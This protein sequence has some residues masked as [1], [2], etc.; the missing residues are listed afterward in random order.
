MVGKRMHLSAPVDWCAG[1][2]VEEAAHVVEVV[3]YPLCMVV[4]A[5]TC[6]LCTTCTRCCRFL[7]QSAMMAERHCDC[8]LPQHLTCGQPALQK[9]G[10]MH[11]HHY[12][13]M[14]SAPGHCVI[15]KIQSAINMPQAV[16]RMPAPAPRRC[17]W[18]CCA[19]AGRSSRCACAAS[20]CTHPALDPL[21]YQNWRF[22]QA[23]CS[24]GARHQHGV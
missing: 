9:A 1:G 18:R 7:L 21:R 11:L 10:C 22:E 2:H 15:H 24:A 3:I 13:D 16:R 4:C 17:S 12:G 6:A 23:G 5:V 20:Q 8:Q 14:I 19:R